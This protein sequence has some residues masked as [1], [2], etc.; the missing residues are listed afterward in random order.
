MRSSER[1]NGQVIRLAITETKGNKMKQSTKL[2]RKQDG[3]ARSQAKGAKRKAVVTF[4]LGHAICDALEKQGETVRTAICA[5]QGCNPES[6]LQAML[7]VTERRDVKIKAVTGERKDKRIASLRVMYSRISV[8]LKAIHAKLNLEKIFS[9]AS[10]AEMYAFASNKAKKSD[11]RSGK[12]LTADQF[13]DY[14]D[15]VSRIVGEQPGKT[16]KQTE[17]DK[18]SLQIARLEQHLRDVIGTLAKYQHVTVIPVRDM[19]GLIAKR[20]QH[21][22]LV[23]K[24][25]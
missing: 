21:V 4:K 12:P 7:E 17:R 18:F 2:S 6:V 22:K 9:A 19:L 10:F 8:I 23:R 14:T 25:A 11:K 24:A 15:K 20:K 13:K 1:T 16:A 5:L 3:Q